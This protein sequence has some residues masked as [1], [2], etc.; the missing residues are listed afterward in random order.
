MRTI[1]FCDVPK[2]PYGAAI[3]ETVLNSSERTELHNHDFC[4]LFFMK[5]GELT[6]FLNSEAFVLRRGDFCLIRQ[7]DIHCFQ[8]KSEETASFVN[9]SFPVDF[10]H[11]MLRSA[12]LDNNH[13][14]FSDK[15]T[16]NTTQMLA[17]EEL[18]NLLLKVALSSEENVSCKRALLTSLLQTILLS[19][20]ILDA[21]SPAEIPLWLSQAINALQ[22]PEILQQGITGLV[23]VCGRSQEH[24]TR[25]L[26]K[27]YHQTPSQI[28]NKLRIAQAQKLLA[29]TDLSI[30]DISMT[31]GYESVSYFTDSF[32]SRSECRR[33]HTGIPCT[34]SFRPYHFVHAVR[35][36]SL[37]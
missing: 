10:C 18:L 30:L 31:V 29:S 23:R 22:K 32:C 25:Q 13:N 3:I 26:Q 20:T 2:Q 16:L 14:T 4:E 17:V 28:I 8:K 35:P 33:G 6:H 36:G 34:A 27:Y 15:G 9:I 11:H 7:T 1:H 37:P 12:G 19:Q 5:R 24:I 21:Q